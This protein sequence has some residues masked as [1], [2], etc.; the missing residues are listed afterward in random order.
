MRTWGEELEILPLQNLEVDIQG[1]RN[2][3][4]IVTNHDNIHPNS[5]LTVRL[6]FLNEDH[7][8]LLIN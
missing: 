3:I 1:Y 5:N 8:N 7:Y 6:Y 4:S 2:V